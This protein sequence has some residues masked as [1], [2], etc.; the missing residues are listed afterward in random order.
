MADSKNPTYI[1]NEE[2]QALNKELG[3]IIP[4]GVLT[5]T[6]PH[7]IAFFRTV[8]LMYM[9]ELIKKEMVREMLNDFISIPDQNKPDFNR[10][11]ADFAEVQANRKGQL[12]E[13]FQTKMME[14]DLNYLVKILPEDMGQKLMYYVNT[15]EEMPEDMMD[16]MEQEAVIGGD[17][18]AAEKLR[19]A[20]G[21]RSK[22]DASSLEEGGQVLMPTDI[23]DRFDLDEMQDTPL[24]SNSTLPQRTPTL[25]PVLPKMP[26]QPSQAV[27]PSQYPNN[28][29]RPA[30]GTIRPA[31]P[32]VSQNI[33]PV[34]QN[35]VIRP[36]SPAPVR[37]ELDPYGEF[38]NDTP[39]SNQIPTNN[40]AAGIHASKPKG[41]DDLVK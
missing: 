39:T 29:A 27:Q 20:L 7:W 4:S 34:Q 21:G 1:S 8:R 10:N 35:G 16:D 22:F 17:E 26:M 13:L 33:S 40:V 5:E 30:L 19:R 6:I 3:L 25:S 11:L 18:L 32:Q 38:L 9:S 24:P 15:G 37:D 12:D 28:Q 36:S 14:D 41:L 31:R 23:A 2:E